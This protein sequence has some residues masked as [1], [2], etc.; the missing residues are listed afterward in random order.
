[1][2]HLTMLRVNQAKQLLVRH[3]ELGIKQVADL[4]GFG[5]Q[6]YFTRVFTRETGLSPSAWRAAAQAASA[7]AAVRPGTPR[8][9]PPG[10]A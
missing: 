10:S 9:R 2:R 4:V 5:D 8:D 7:G 6:L 1:M 3:G